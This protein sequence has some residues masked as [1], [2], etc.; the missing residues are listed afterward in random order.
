VLFPELY[1]IASKLNQLI[2]DRYYVLWAGS[3][4]SIPAGYPD[5]VKTLEELCLACKVQYLISQERSA[6]YII[7]KAEEC[8]NA[9]VRAYKK[10]LADLF[11]RPVVST[12]N[13]YLLLMKLPFKGYVTTNFDPLLLEAA[14]LSK[15]N[16]IY[17]YPSLNYGMLYEDECPVF[18]I[19]G[20]ARHGD[21]PIGDNL[22]LASSDF[23]EAYDGN[24][25]NFLES[26]LTFDPILFLGC[27][28]EEPSIKA[29]FQRVHKIHS[30]IQETHGIELPE[31]YILLPR[32]L[33]EEERSQDAINSTEEE[34]F[35]AMGINTIRYTLHDDSYWEIERILKYMLE[36]RGDIKPLVPKSGFP[37]V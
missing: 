32:H 28:L 20:L 5:W 2:K 19:H 6:E 24:V 29:T 21:E 30:K 15:Y 17:S 34:R 9:D 37:R 18:Y 10:T 14:A 27:R 12:R 7:A 26:L 23:D 31:R 13:A 1:Q 36:M 3:G 4:L 25:R 8:K 11:G 33:E 16:N 22:V 35:Q